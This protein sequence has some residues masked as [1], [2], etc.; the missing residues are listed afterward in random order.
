MVERHEWR[1]VQRHMRRIGR[2]KNPEADVPLTD[3]NE[4]RLPPEF[5]AAL[6]AYERLTG[7][8]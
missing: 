8:T 5:R 4:P 1:I 3:P 7:A 6:Q 2:S